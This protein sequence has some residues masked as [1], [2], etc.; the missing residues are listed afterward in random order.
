LESDRLIT[1]FEEAYEFDIKE[2]RE[3]FGEGIAVYLTSCVISQT[4]PV[5]ALYHAPFFP[6]SVFL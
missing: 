1:R 3:V 2:V 6:A 5:M 4:I